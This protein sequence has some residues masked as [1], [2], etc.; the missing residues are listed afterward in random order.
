MADGALSEGGG[1]S[2]LAAAR[3]VR[4]GVDDG[5]CANCANASLSLGASIAE[6]A[7]AVNQAG[8]AP[9]SSSRGVEGGPDAGI[10]GSGALNE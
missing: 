5:L 2:D 3:E 10:A 4:W 9:L 8:G 1:V 6:S 7:A